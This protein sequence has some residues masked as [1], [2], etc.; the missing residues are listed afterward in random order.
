MTD[1]RSNAGNAGMSAEEWEEWFADKHI[2]TADRA[3]Y[4]DADDT[5]PEYSLG[6]NSRPRE[7]VAAGSITVHQHTSRIAYPDVE[8]DYRVYVPAQYDGSVPASLIVFLD[9]L[10]YLAGDFR[11]DV[12]WTIS[13]PT[14]RSR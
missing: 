9:G 10:E 7:G 13:S 5:W 4:A 6:S 12:A 3:A 2:T 14:A 8:R 1:E 11:A